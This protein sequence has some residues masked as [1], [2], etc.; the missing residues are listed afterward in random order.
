MPT[1]FAQTPAQQQPQAPSTIQADLA[2][3]METE[4]TAVFLIHPTG[5]STIA[6]SFSQ[7]NTQNADKLYVYDGTDASAP[8]PTSDTKQ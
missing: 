3:I 7:F 8:L 2:A 4:K 1:P 6:L 5:G